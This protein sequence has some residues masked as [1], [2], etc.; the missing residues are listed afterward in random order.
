[1]PAVVRR[2]SRVAASVLVAVIGTMCLTGC[3][4][5][6]QVPDVVGMA[7]DDAHN[8]LKDLG[9]EE[10]EDDD[11]FGDR[12]MLRDANWVVL[13]Q[14]PSA[15]RKGELD[16]TVTLRVGKIDEKRSQDLLPD[17]SPVLMEVKAEAAAKA[18]SDAKKKAKSAKKKAAAAARKEAER[19]AKG[20]IRAEQYGEE[21]PFTVPAGQ[22][23]CREPI[24]KGFGKVTVTLAGDEYAL[25]GS[26]RG[27]KD[28]DGL[29][30][31]K[32]IAESPLW[33]EDPRY[34]DGARVSYPQLIED[35]LKLC[36]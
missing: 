3:G 2:R 36:K 14:E 10:F 28:E 33:R 35:G 11:L 18:A 24:S 20:F 12:T 21:W 29:P 6:A 27:S 8:E 31:W 23:H 34:G 16:S 1:M 13:E 22:L 5:E 4:P 15:G 7:L 30:D 19:R 17:D 26:A 9:F 32:D 25:N